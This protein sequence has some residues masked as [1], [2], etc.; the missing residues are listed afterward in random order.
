MFLKNGDENLFC[1]A[2]RALRYMLYKLKF[3]STSSE[4]S[5]VNH[6]EWHHHRW[7]L[8]AGSHRRR[9]RQ[10]FR[11]SCQAW[12]LWAP[13][14]GEYGQLYGEVVKEWLQGAHGNRGRGARLVASARTTLSVRKMCV[15]AAGTSVYWLSSTTR[16]YRISEIMKRK[17]N[18]PPLKLCCPTEK[19]ISTRIFLWIKSGWALISW[20]RARFN[21]Q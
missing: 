15:F 17:L 1:K 14:A 9:S 19:S 3:R 13:T 7:R 8:R 20:N 12:V 5:L 2:R 21:T 16:H 6:I 4:R 10:N 11:L 18:G